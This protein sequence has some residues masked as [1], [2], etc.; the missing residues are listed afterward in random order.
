MEVQEILSHL[1]RNEGHFARSA[2]REAV[3]HRDEII[4][5]LLEVLESAA[6]DPQSFARDPNRMIHL[7]AMYLL[8][9]FRETRAYPL[10]VQMFSAPG[11]LP[12]DLAGDTVTEGLDSILASVSDGDMTGMA[13]L[14]ENERANE[15]VRS[16]ALKGLVTL[17]ACGKRSRDEM[18]AY[19]KGLF[20]TLEPTYSLIWNS[21]ASRCRD[22]GPE[23]VREDLRRVHEQGLIDEFY[24]RWE[25]SES[26]GVGKEAAMKALKGRYRLIDDAEKEMSWWACFE[27]NK[28]R[29][30]KLGWDTPIRKAPKVGRNEPCPCGSGK[31][32]KK[33]CGR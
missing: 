22:L 23:E 16:A 5:P 8:A 26:A 3:A 10:L 4:P 11:E 2:V 14:V 27:E 29:K 31:K 12:F 28:H 33:C 25:D 18:M 19:F 32:F 1:E 24:I 7:Y 9:Q 6:R 21:L 17:V 20:R 15:Y 13:S 30:V